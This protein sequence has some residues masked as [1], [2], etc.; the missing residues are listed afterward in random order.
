MKWLPFLLGLVLLAYPFA[1]YYGLNEWGIGAV[2]GILALVFFLRMIVS[3]KT[4]LRELKYMLWLGSGAGL[5]I[6]SLAYLFKNTRWLTYY[7]VIV[8]LLFFSFFLISLWQK[9][10]IIERFARL[11]EP[12]LPDYARRYT[13]SV[14]KVWCVFFIINGTISLIT[15]FMSLDIWTF[16]NGFISYVLIGLLFLLEF[17]TRGYVKKK[18]V[19]SSDHGV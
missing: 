19:K 9:E 15:S 5:I 11:L 10:T 7:P 6:V 3:S 2:A 14:T 4:R 18:N 8:N 12:E 17:I 1:V 13:R 16:Y